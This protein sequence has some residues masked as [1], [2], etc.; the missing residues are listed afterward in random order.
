MRGTDRSVMRAMKWQVPLERQMEVD[1]AGQKRKHAQRE[2]HKETE[3]IKIRPGHKSPRARHLLPQL[4]VA[5]RE[6]EFEIRTLLPAGRPTPGRPGSIAKCR[7]GRRMTAAL[8]SSVVMI[9]RVQNLSEA[10]GQVGRTE[11]FRQEQN[12]P[13]RVFVLR[14]DQKCTL[15]RRIRRELF[16]A[17]KKPGIDFRVNR[18]QFRLQARRVA[19]R[20]IHEK[21]GIDAEESCQEFARG[22]RQVRPGAILDLREIRL[23]QTAADFAL[24]RGGQLL[25]GHRTAQSAERTFDG[26]EGAEFLAKFHGGLAYCNLQIWYHILLFCQAKSDEPSMIS[27]C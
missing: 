9:A 22:V 1:C 4:A 14:D 7:S 10:L 27:I 2:A 11:N 3:K 16:G 24:H 26:A 25:L 12:R 15:K 6:L 8:L 18:T 13:A 17:G 19:F 20:V 5:V 21:A 23:A